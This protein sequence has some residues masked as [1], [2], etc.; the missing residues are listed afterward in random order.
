MKILFVNDTSQFH[1][2][3]W[4]ACEV[5]VSELVRGGHEIIAEQSKSQL[6]MQGLETADAVLVNGEG[7]LHDDTPRTIRILQLLELA[8]RAGKPTAICNA[9]WFRMGGRYD[10]VLRKLERFD[11]RESLSRDALRQCHGVEAGLYLDAS[12]F[13]PAT[14]DL[15]RHTRKRVRMTDL[16]WP[17]L[18]GFARPT[19]GQLSKFDFL[20]M[21]G[22]SWQ[23][24]LDH[25][26]ASDVLLTG[27]HHGVYAACRARVPFVALSGNTPKIEGL[28]SWAGLDLPVTNDVANLGG[29]LAGIGRYRGA[30]EKLFDWMERQPAWVSPF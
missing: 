17:E 10:H 28:A 18:R 9:S 6:D 3:S 2:G 26:G 14:P 5:I 23:A 24:M 4:A 1:C 29:M 16:Y 27:R 11:V 15:S 21:E 22:L 19:G 25:V 8:Q 30:F 20:A 13:H 12:Y 7:T